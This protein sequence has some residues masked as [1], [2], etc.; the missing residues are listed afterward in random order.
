MEQLRTLVTVP[1]LS[2]V[3]GPLGSLLRGS[4]MLCTPTD[5][6]GQGGQGSQSLMGSPGILMQISQDCFCDLL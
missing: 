5:L 6:V 2:W 3:S 1:T 4:T